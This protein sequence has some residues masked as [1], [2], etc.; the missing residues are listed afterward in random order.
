MSFDSCVAGCA[1]RARVFLSPVRLG[2]RRAS[3]GGRAIALLIGLLVFRLA[4]ADGT[5]PAPDVGSTPG[6]YV[7]PC[8][9]A[10]SDDADTLYVACADARQV[11][12]V[13][14]PGENVTRRVDLPARP[15]G[16]TLAPDGSTLLVTCAAPKSTVAVLDAAS[17]E[18]L[19]AI[20]VG[21]TAMG[22]AIA[23]DGKRAYVCN[24][25]TGDV[26]VIDLAAREEV[27]RVAAVRE[28][29]A[30]AVTPDG[31]TVL[32]ANHL[33]KRRTHVFL[34]FDVTPVVTLIDAETLETT[35]VELP[36]GAHSL[37]AVAVL[38]D[39]DHALVTHLMANFEEIPFRVDMGWINTNV[40]SIVDLRRRKVVATIGMDENDE[41]AGNP[42]DVAC[43]ADGST[44]AVSL[45]GTHQLGLIEGPVLLSDH[46]RRT[47]QPMMGVWPIY[48][49]LGGSLWRRVDL[50]GSGP[51]GLAVAGSKVY[52][53]EYFSDRVAVV[54]LE[55][56]GEDSPN[57]IAL[58]PKPRLTPKR[59]GEMHFHDA[60]LCY[61]NWQSCASCH[62]DGRA[63]GLNWDLM[64]D[65]TG[66]LKNTKS[67]VFAHETPPSMAEGVRASA[68][69]A[70]RSGLAHILFI[71][72]MEEEAA[73][74][75][76][77]LRSLR[78]VPSPHLV[79]GR[80]SPAAERGRALF[81]S[82]RVACRRCHP[83]PRYTDLK[84]HDVGTKNSRERTRRFDTPTLVEVWRT[85]P[86]LH[87]GRY[88][89]IRELLVEGKHGLRRGISD[90]L[91][92]QEIDD[93][94]QFVLS[95]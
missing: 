95:L 32:V 76:A 47:M 15:T 86:Y 21:H 62:P 61:Q 18:R 39:G 2:A 68:E 29:V 26:S 49:G 10:V 25:F 17:G 42:W 63:D 52:V 57:T 60:T 92:E 9:L 45:S 53:A 16:L 59:R 91:T 27:A 48:L 33:P 87:D 43:S 37:R 20:P 73:A 50:P 56:M 30:A 35:A 90:N 34:S 38:P 66:N 80:L 64:N 67:M 19:G 54:D 41:G 89:T 55:T 75:D 40:M 44:V 22:P 12:W 69:V 11:F 51:R 58:G 31:R 6:S 1:R 23:P 94:V 24:R 74:I 82:E 5:I 93:L 28:P 85:P 46:A 83:A 78:P 14:L 7:G 13:D 72:H 36:H 84:R 3:G 70:V 81:E 71:H 4:M 88:L 65:G 77:Y 79:D 8:A